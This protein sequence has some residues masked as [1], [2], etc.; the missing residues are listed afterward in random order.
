MRKV[1]A[2]RIIRMAEKLE[3]IKKQKAGLLMQLRKLSADEDFYSK[4]LRQRIGEDFTYDGDEYV[5]AVY[6]QRHERA[7]LDQSAV[8]KILGKRTPYKKVVVHSI[9]VD[10]L[11]E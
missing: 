2:K 3:S 4:V 6:F 10:Y 11:Y 8:K 5:K 1:K 7:I 9:R